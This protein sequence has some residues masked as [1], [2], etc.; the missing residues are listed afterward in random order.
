MVKTGGENFQEW[1]EVVDAVYS[2]NGAS[3]EAIFVHGWPDLIKETMAFVAKLYLESDRPKVVLNGLATY[4]VGAPGVSKCRDLLLEHG[5]VA[6]D[7]HEIPDAKYTHA[8]AD[9]FMKFAASRA[10]SSAT[11]VSVPQHLL[12]A[13]LTDF[14]VMKTAGLT[15]SLYPRIVPRESFGWQEMYE[16]M[17]LLK[18]EPERATRLARFATECVRV[19]EYRARMEAG[20]KG[21]DIASISEAH[22]YLHRHKR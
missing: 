14:A 16:F 21:Y 3:R 17:P 4:G 9:E 2:G 22:K 12:R 5:V 6:S 15:L 19:L 18:K 20:E 7:I 11:I 13:F 1:L 10:L 8:E